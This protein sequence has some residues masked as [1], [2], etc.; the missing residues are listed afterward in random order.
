[1]VLDPE[2]PIVM[3]S[4]SGQVPALL[5]LRIH[6]VTQGAQEPGVPHR[7]GGTHLVTPRLASLPSSWGPHFVELPVV[8]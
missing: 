7:C 8:R 2:L 1:M 6:S 5:W 4:F 3:L